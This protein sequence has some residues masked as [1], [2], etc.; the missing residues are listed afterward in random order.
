MITSRERVRKAL[1]HEETDRVPV[2]FGG[3]RVTGVAA[4]AY[5]RL[6]E[7]LGMREEVRVYD[8]KQQLA[9]PS[10]AMINRMGGDVVQLHRLAPSTGMSFLCLDAWKHGTLVDGTAGLVPEGYEPVF[11]GDGTIEIWHEGMLYAR[12]PATSLYFDVCPQ[13]LANAE[14]AADIDRYVWPDAWTAREER[15]LTAEVKRLHEGTDKALFAGLPLMVCSFFE[16]GSVLFG[17]ERFMENLVL[18]PEMME[19]WLDVKLEHDLCILE[20]FL[21]VAGPS[22]E[23][24]QMNDDFGAQEALQISPGMFREIFKPRMKRWIAFVKARTQAK[25]FLHC[26]GAVRELLPDF[27]EIGIDVLNPLQTGA[28]DMDP[29]SIKR[30][31]GRDL[32]FW[33]A[34]VDTQ[35]TLPFGSIADIQREV[36]E[37][38]SL[39]S[40]G[41]GFVFGTIHNIQ[42]DIPPEKIVAVFDTAR[43]NGR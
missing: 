11:K 21:A 23:A 40:K 10:M 15:W 25:V 4:V 9:E 3:S 27:I 14:T 18:N 42:P 16:I 5:R 43:E 28:R 37:R 24:I 31:Y 1:N 35:T 6:A 19:H 38:V 36:R 7:H 33:G 26:D 32:S 41:G 8:I 39:L 22:I 30:E 12:R 34:G 17:Y 29:E 2:D 13:P 20:R